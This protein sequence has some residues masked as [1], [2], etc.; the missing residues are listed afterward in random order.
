MTIVYVVNDG[1]GDG[2]FYFS[3]LN[4]AKWDAQKAANALGRDVDVAKNTVAK[5][6]ARELAVALLRNQ[7]WSASSVVVFTAG[8]KELARIDQ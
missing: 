4:D 8:P 6:P 2:P 7:G 5:I 3:R 1:T